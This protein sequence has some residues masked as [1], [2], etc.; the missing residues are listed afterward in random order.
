MNLK[1]E[2]IKARIVF[3]EILP[4]LLLVGLSAGSAWGDNSVCLSCHQDSMPHLSN[5]EEAWNKSHPDKEFVRQ[6]AFSESFA[7][8]KVHISAS[9][10]EEDFLEKVVEWAKI[11]RIVL[12]VTVIGGMVFLLLCF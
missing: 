7:K 9:I 11:L 4:V 8:E 1:E 2:W 6:H 5:I 10:A 12:I 3:C